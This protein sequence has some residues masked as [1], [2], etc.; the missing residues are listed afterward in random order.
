[1][2][3]IYLLYLRKKAPILAQKTAMAIAARIWHLTLF[4]GQIVEAP[5]TNTATVMLMVQLSLKSFLDI[6]DIS[7]ARLHQQLASLQRALATAA[8]QDN[9]HTFNHIAVTHATEHDLANLR[10]EMWINF[11]VG[12]ID[13][14]D[15]NSPYRVTDK[16]KFHARAYVNQNCARI[17]QN[18]FMCLLWRQT[19]Y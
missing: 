4:P 13:P 12:F 5:T 14:R 16:Q 1:M 3:A 2:V 9:R 18:Q 17:I 6:E 11:P 10:D 7:H 19:F 15:V 8:N